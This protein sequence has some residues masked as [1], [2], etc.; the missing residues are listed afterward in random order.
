MGVAQLQESS[1]T[2]YIRK[3]KLAPFLSPLPDRRLKV[4]MDG[5]EV[6]EKFF[7]ETFTQTAP[8]EVSLRP[9]DR[10][11]GADDEYILQEPL[12][13]GAV[14]HVWSAR[15]TAGPELVAVKVML[16][17]KD[18]LSES[19]L[20]NVRE[21]FRREAKNG[22]VISHPCVI[23]YLDFGN[24]E[25]N[26]FLVMELA[27]GS[28]ADELRDGEIAEEDAAEIVAAVA[29]ALVHL[30]QRGC[31]HRDVKPANILR[32]ES[33]YKLGDLGIVR[34]SDFD[35]SFTRGGTITRQSVQLGSWF[36]MA[37]E[38]QESP[39]EA[40][41]ASDVYALGVSWIEML[42]GKLPSPQAVGALAFE[43]PNLPGN[44]VDLVRRMVAYHPEE[45][46]TL[47]EITTLLASAYS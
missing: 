7:D 35:E 13:S 34:W 17:R 44:V 12:G 28:V 47:E 32:L 39:H 4:L 33:G 31:P 46:A 19:K 45:R 37:P 11:S 1:L 42:S 9:A 6:S 14:G 29:S 30:H 3:N 38:Q 22:A 16:P 26:P 10:L 41:P 20:P 43:L 21:R 8:R 25:K 24:I 15:T 23:N 40:V 36:Y 27:G 2:T 5:D 18:L